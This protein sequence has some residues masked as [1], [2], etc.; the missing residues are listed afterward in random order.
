MKGEE[1]RQP[2]GHK[3]IAV[4]MLRLSGHLIEDASLRLSPE[5]AKRGA[6]A[7]SIQKALS[8]LAWDVEMKATDDGRA[9]MSIYPNEAFSSGR[10]TQSDAEMMDA[11]AAAGFN[12]SI[13][14]KGEQG[15]GVEYAMG[16]FRKFAVQFTF[17]EADDEGNW[18]FPDDEEPES[19]LARHGF[20]ETDLGG[21]DFGYLRDGLSVTISS[22]TDNG[23]INDTTS[24]CQVSFD[25]AEEFMAVLRPDLN[26]A[27]E[28]AMAYETH[29]TL[30]QDASGHPYEARA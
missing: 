14:V 20:F 3:F 9:Y 30:P 17:D 18:S 25:D 4:G 22:S 23:R 21:G 2:I 1:M 11:L 19:V 27:I 8:Q 24:E 10:W 15:C 5:L 26:A 28:T 12:G 6:A 13:F 7:T 29:R 16:Y